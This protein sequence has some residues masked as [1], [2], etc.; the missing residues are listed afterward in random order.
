MDL[1]S[2]AFL[3]LG[4]VSVLALHSLVLRKFEVDHLAVTII[5]TSWVVYGA[6]AYLIHAGPATR[7]VTSFWISLWL[8][9]SAYRAFFHPLSEYPGPFAARLSKWWTVGQCWNS[10]MH[11]HKIQ[12]QLQKEYGDYVRTGMS[13]I[14]YPSSNCDKLT[15]PG[16]REITIFDVDALL[17]VHG[18]QSKTSKAPFYDMMEKSLHINRDKQFHRQRR[19]IWDNAFKA[20]QFPHV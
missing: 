6:L 13:R 3:L 2:P 12:Q 1:D 19:R 5:V 10:D 18:G 9:I 20:S 7:V 8:W 15:L 11:F 16:P 17:S 4:P 14:V